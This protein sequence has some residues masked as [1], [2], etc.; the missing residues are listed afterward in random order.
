[1]KNLVWVLDWISRKR[2]LG[3]L[4]NLIRE[5]L[6]TDNASYQNHFRI[7]FYW[8]SLGRLSANKVPQIWPLLVI[9]VLWTLHM[10]MTS[11]F[12]CKLDDHFRGRMDAH[13]VR[14]LK[15]FAK[16]FKQ[17]KKQPQNMHK[18]PLWV[19]YHW[20]LKL[21]GTQLP[22]YKSP[23]LSPLGFFGDASPPAWCVSSD[24]WVVISV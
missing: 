22:G 8:H 7:N 21:E 9:F 20:S 15:F 4:D 10:F 13:F 6:I 18:W 17:T 23:S 12:F 3:T 14:L 16:K 19:M 1:M 5:L 24:T 11:I 2:V